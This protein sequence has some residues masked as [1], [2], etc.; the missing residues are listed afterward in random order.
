M[1]FFTIHGADALGGARPARA[2][3]VTSDFSWAAFAFG[4]LWLLAH[5]LW[6]AAFA[7][8]LAEGA[9]FGAILQGV[10]AP[11]AGLPLSFALSLLAGLEG[12]E[13]RRRALARRGLPP[14]DVVAASDG[15]QALAAFLNAREARAS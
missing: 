8:I 15:D 11:Q 2:Q 3:T 5:R 12:H 10:L 7:F 6:L 14:E 9:V 4:P 13:W 1:A